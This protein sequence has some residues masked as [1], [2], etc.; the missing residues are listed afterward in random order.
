MN[1]CPAERTGDGDAPEELYLFK[2]N[3]QGNF[4]AKHLEAE[5][6]DLSRQPAVTF[7]D[8]AGMEGT[9]E[10]LQEVIAYL[11]DPDRFYALGARPPRGILLAGPSGTGKTLMA[12]AVAGEAMVAPW[13]QR[14]DQ[15]GLIFHHF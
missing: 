10:E 6:K 12:R 13:S 1:R 3:N 8:V 14:L 15:G 2:S 5:S 7:S 4:T 11:R 9:K